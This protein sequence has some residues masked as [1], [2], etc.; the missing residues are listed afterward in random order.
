M[1]TDVS[2]KLPRVLTGVSTRP[3]PADGGFD[4]TAAC[5]RRFRRDRVRAQRPIVMST[6][7][8]RISTR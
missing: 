4:E 2:T 3:P 1:L 6:V 7:S 8:P 5:L